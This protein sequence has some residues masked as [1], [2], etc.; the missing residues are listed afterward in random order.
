MKI[1]ILIYR[2]YPYISAN[3]AIGYEIG[4]ELSKRDG[5]EV[6][7]IGRKE[8]KSQET[9]F[10]Y[11]GNKIRFLNEKIENKL[12]Q[13]VKNVLKK[14]LGEKLFLGTDAKSLRKI[15]KQEKIDAL[16]CVIAPIDNARIV[17]KAHLSIPCILHQ[18]DPFYHHE[19]KVDNKKKEEFLKV[20][21]SFQTIYTTNLLIEEYK[22]DEAFNKVINKFAVAEFPLLKPFKITKDILKHQEKVQL[23][24]AGSFY[25]TLRSS[26]ILLKLKNILPNNYQI[27]FCGTCDNE[28]DYNLLKES[29]IICKGKL[30][31]DQ[32]LEEYQKSDILINI[33]NTV[34]L[35]MGSKLISYIAIGKPI[36]NIMQFNDCTIEVLSEYPYAFN[37]LAAEIEGQRELIL[38]FVKKHKNSL[39]LYEEVEKKYIKYTP[40]YVSKSIMKVLE[41]E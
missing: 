18:L 7:Y 30:L 1:G 26:K 11:K 20:I 41:K 2:Q 23:L 35:Q 37:V 27:V 5:C 21:K 33:G 13:K 17:H 14:Y 31:P 3:T 12:F 24:Y 38:D 32:L 6:V 29:G 40:G 39:A 9:V 34:K 10:C 25:K 8:N 28:S 36:L 4:E 19:D 15:V 16:I 22:K